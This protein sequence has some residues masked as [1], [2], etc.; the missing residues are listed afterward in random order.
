MTVAT[1]TRMLML[2][3][4]GTFLCPN[5]G[6]TM[7]LRYLW[8]LRD[9]GQ[10]KNYDWGGMV[11]T[12]LL[13]F[14]TQLSRRSLSSLGANEEIAR[15]RVGHVVSGTLGDYFEFVQTQLQGCLAGIPVTSASSSEEEEEE[16]E[17]PLSH[18]SS[19]SSS[20]MET[21]PHFLGWQYEVMNPDRKET[22]RVAPLEV[23]RGDLPVGG[24]G[25]RMML[26]LYFNFPVKTGKWICSFDFSTKSNFLGY[27]L[28]GI[29]ALRNV[30]IK[31]DFLRV[32]VKFWDPGGYV[33]P[34]KTAELCPTIE[35]FST[36][37][38]YDP[39]IKSVAVS[40]DP[41]HREILSDALGLPTLVTGSMIE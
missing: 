31:W 18:T 35:E 16:K 5:L 38:G 1:G 2:L 29:K 15:A 34:F 26:N 19:S 24:P 11:Y 7:S 28:K 20:F 6:S 8:S 12:T 23:G 40:C 21:Y 14:M 36:I 30:K 41:R 17:N 39:N 9:I 33:F 10:I 3:L 13:H 22:L 27:K 32:A 25:V 37:L 4:V